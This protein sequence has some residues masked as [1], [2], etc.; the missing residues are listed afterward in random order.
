[1]V[2]DVQSNGRTTIEDT[3]S[4]PPT[5]RAAE[6]GEATKLAL[7]NMHTE[8]MTVVLRQSGETR[9][10]VQD[11]QGFVSVW[12][13][14]TPG[15]RVSLGRVRGTFEKPRIFDDRIEVKRMDGDI[16][17]QQRHVLSMEFSTKVGAATIKADLDYYD[18]EEKPIEL[19]LRPE[20]GPAASLTAVAAS[21]RSSF[22]ERLEVS[23]E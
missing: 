4:T 6:A 1:V 3:F 9:F 2:I 7:D 12:R 20:P 21:I 14:G 19:V 10:V 23:I 5:H 22:S 17:G 15:V 18:R 13:E 8:N 11:V 16:W